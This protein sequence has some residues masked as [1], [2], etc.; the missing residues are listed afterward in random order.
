MADACIKSGISLL[1]N[2]PLHA[3]ICDDADR[4]KPTVVA[5]PESE[6]GQAFLG[7]ADRIGREIEL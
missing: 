3:R 6:R 2:I 1:G 7:I 4:G 5:E